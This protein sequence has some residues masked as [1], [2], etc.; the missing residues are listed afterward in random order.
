MFPWSVLNTEDREMNQKV[1]AEKV[2]FDVD[3][4]YGRA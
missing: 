2:Q 4:A 3:T 1:S